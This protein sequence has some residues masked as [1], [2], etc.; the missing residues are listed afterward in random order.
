MC[1]QKTPYNW[2]EQLYARHGETIATYLQVKVL[3]SLK[4]KLDEFLLREFV[5]RGENHQL[6]NKW[7][8][9]FFIYLDRY[10]VKYQQLPT[11]NDAGMKK[12]KQIVYDSVKKDVTA[13]ILRMIKEEREGNVVD[14]DLI[15]RCVDIY[16][17]MGMGNVDA[18]ETDFEQ[19]FLESSR[20]FY[21]SKADGWIVSDST[22]SYLLKIE[23]I[24]NDE[25]SRVNNYLVFTTETKLTSVLEK[26]TLEKRETELLDKE[27]SGLRVMLINDM[28]DDLSR[29]FKL[30]SRIS[31]G[32]DPI[33][34]I[35]KQHIL[36]IG[37]EKI[38][39]YVARCESEGNAPSAAA[40][41]MKGPPPAKGGDKGGEEKEG[42]KSGG[43]TEKDDPQFIKDL[44][45]VHSKFVKMVNEQFGANPLFQKALKDAFVELC[46]KDTGKQKTTDLIASFCDRLL[47]SG[48]SEKL[49]DS[50]IE[51]FL[52]KTVELFSY[53]T[54]KDA[55]AEIYRH[56]LAK[57]LINQK[58]AS[59][60][61]ERLMITKLKLR[62]GAQYT[63]KFEGMMN[64]LAIGGEQS[65]AFM[66]FCNENP[67]KAGI[68]KVDFTVQVLTTGHW[69]QYKTLSEI[70][71]PPI[72]QRC[73]QVFKDYYDMKTNHR[74]L[75]W[76]HSLGAVVVK[77]NFKK[78]IDIEGTTLQAVVLLTFNSDSL[79][80]T[81]NGAPIPFKSLQEYLNMPEDILKKVLHSLSCGK[82]KVLKKIGEGEGGSGDKGI[83]TTDSFSF[84]EAFA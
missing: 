52:E 24:L 65:A 21:G 59:D 30:F 41:A 43:S 80:G 44:L 73:T 79:G 9:K 14:R 2:S 37:N 78:P 7:C 64:D 19:P 82:F 13:S 45:E 29:L 74:R 66:A 3:Q 10:H 68:G 49:N 25:K 40:P 18:Y 53:L 5:Q 70:N 47:K 58:S 72:M 56:Q 20:E 17:K 4:S 55:F 69:P 28:L 50:E 54:D 77:G 12:Y 46:N 62:C 22:P 36:N 27:N 71:F 35:F 15:K 6:M 84:N 39:A 8:T 48:S 33:A 63:A 81:T 57:R 26:E 23:K 76:T 16:V 1:T 42:D 75:Q 61:M 38:E 34:E 83:K 60:E 31:N 32:L 11:L 51:E 67:D